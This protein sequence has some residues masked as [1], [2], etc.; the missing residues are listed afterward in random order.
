MSSPAAAIATTGGQA[1]LRS[2]MTGLVRRFARG[3][4]ESW[5]RRRYPPHEYMKL[6]LRSSP[7]AVRA[8]D[9][10]IK[11]TVAIQNDN[12]FSVEVLLL[13]C[14]FWV[15]GFGGVPLHFCR[16]GEIGPRAALS[17]E[18]WQAAPFR[19]ARKFEE[20]EMRNQALTCGF[21][22]VRLV[23]GEPYS[24]RGWDVRTIP[25][26]PTSTRIWIGN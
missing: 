19:L 7:E 12:E 25:V 10:M 14:R 21:E 18:Y 5:L 4:S 6:V 3:H 11:G 23:L 24:A 13:D 9:G 26:E 1:L 16:V 8:S 2:A 15:T 22:I 17:L 20:P